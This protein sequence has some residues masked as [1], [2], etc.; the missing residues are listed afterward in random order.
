MR[1]TGTGNTSHNT[2]C[3]HYIVRR[4]ASKLIFACF[5]LILFLRRVLDLMVDRHREMVSAALI[6]GGGRDSWMSTGDISPVKTS[7]TNYN[8]KIK[9][10]Q[11]NYT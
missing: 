10:K 7:T 1:S 11:K 4:M 3:T 8:N 2:Q 6:V 9:I 5:F